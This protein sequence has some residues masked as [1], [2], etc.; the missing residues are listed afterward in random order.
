MDEVMEGKHG[1]KAPADDGVVDAEFTDV[2][3]GDK[4]AS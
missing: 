1:A 4:K 2:T 3:D